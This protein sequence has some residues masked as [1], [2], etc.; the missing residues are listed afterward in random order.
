MREMT[1]AAKQT[2]PK[3]DLVVADAMR[4]H[5]SIHKEDIIARNIQRGRD[6]GIP[7][8]GK[9]RESCGMPPLYG[10]SRP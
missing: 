9:F 1:G 5:F 7:S 8:Y 10:N 3:M 2:S 4:N 6:H